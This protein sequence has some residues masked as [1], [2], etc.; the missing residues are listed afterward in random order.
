MDHKDVIAMIE[1]TSLPYSYDHFAEGEVPELPY[2][3][4]RYPASDNTAADGM[5]YLTSA[6]LNIELYSDIKDPAAEEKVEAVLNSYG[7]IYNKSEEWIE[8]E[9]LYEVLYEME[10]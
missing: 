5:T 8:S 10:V 9:K 2:I 3:A 4:F 7:I 1:G 6:R